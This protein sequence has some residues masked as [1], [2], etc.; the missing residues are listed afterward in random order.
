MPNCD[1]CGDP[2]Q[3]PRDKNTTGWWRDRCLPC[4]EQAAPDVGRERR[5]PAQWLAETPAP[6][7]WA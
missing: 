6:E 2:L 7:G 1:D 4:I 3:D 5:S